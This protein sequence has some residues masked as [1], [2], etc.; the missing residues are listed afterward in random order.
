MDHGSE[1]MN[2]FKTFILLIVMAALFMFIGR[3]IGGDTGM[4]VALVIAIVMNFVSWFYSDKIVLSMYAA[5]EVD[6][7]AAPN[8]IRIVR[9]LVDNAHLPMP[10][11]YIIPSQNPNAFAT[12]RDPNHAAVAV[13][14]GI[15]NVLSYDEIKG[16]IGHELSHVKNR[17]TLI[18][19]I[20]ATMA[21]AIGM[22]AYMGRFGALFG[23]GDRRG[24]G[25][26]LT[27][28]LW[29]ILAPII[30]MLIQLSISRTREYSADKGGAEFSENPLAL[31]SALRKISSVAERH[32]QQDLAN[33]TTAHMWIASPLSANGI[34]A[35]LSTH[36]PIE[37]RIKRLEQM[38]NG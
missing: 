19:V 17:D 26:I 16:V 36:P 12:G 30:A 18:M 20:A 13:T 35:L 9:E 32:P 27:I 38:A 8:L 25:G 29:A 10:K 6:E 4:F 24:G 11:V 28:L 33:P 1:I 7:A 37:E 5:K 23:F 15:L 14:E 34:M 3:L 31:A 22:L 21:S 2:T